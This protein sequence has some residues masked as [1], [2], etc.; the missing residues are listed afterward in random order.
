[1]LIYVIGYLTRDEKIKEVAKYYTSLGNNVEYV[2]K[3]P[4]LSYRK[5]SRKVL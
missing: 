5:N 3:Q 1:M 2:K 4:H